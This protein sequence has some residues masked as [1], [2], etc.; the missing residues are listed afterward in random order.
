M[1]KLL[2]SQPP[3]IG[4]PTGQFVREIKDLPKALVVIKKT[5]TSIA[6][7][8]P[9]KLNA[10]RRTLM[11][12]TQLFQTL[13]GAL[14]PDANARNHEQGPAYALSARHQLAQLAATG[15]LNQT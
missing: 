6:I 1:P 4:P 11:V 10:K 15:C 12:N 13:K 2:E 7:D 5:G 14:L 8:E 9:Q 3:I